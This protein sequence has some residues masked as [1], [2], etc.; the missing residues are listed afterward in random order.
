MIKISWLLAGIAFSPSVLGGHGFM[1]SFADVEWF[2]EPG[3]LPSELGY[4]FD[5]AAERA[6]L[7]LALDTAQKIDLALNHAAEKLSEAS[8][9]IKNNSLP[10]VT[11]ALDHYAYY[12]GVC[13][14]LMLH[15]GQATNN[16][17]IEKYPAKI[18]ERQMEHLYLISIDYTDMPLNSRKIFTSFFSQGMSRL[19]KLKAATSEKYH[20]SLFFKEEELRWNIE[21]TVQADKQR[22]T[23]E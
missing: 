5:I 17:L 16:D 11:Q 14:D 9:E 7:S 18:I 8:A 21:M 3:I 15:H 12:M 20:E 4:S 23:N 10:E 22:I 19:E 1:N 6:A 2:P 13:T